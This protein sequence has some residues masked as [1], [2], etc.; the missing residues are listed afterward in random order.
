MHRLGNAFLLALIVL[1][2]TKCGFA[3]QTIVGFLGGARAAYGRGAEL[4]R[5]GEYREA[6]SV[7]ETAL[8]SDP[9][10]PD[11]HELL[12]HACVKLGDGD[13]AIDAYTRAIQRGSRRYTVYANRGAVYSLRG[14]W[15][16]ALAD[17]TEGIRIEPDNPACYYNRARIYRGLHQYAKER[18][19]LER[20]YER[21]G[22]N[23][24]AAALAQLLATCPETA[25]RDGQRAVEYA[26]EDCKQV[27]REEYP[28]LSRLAAAH[29]EAGHWDEAVRR[30]EQA[31]QL[32]EGNWR[33]F[34]RTCLELYRFHEPY[35]EF[36]LE[37]VSKQRPHTAGETLLYANVKFIAG[38][39]EEAIA[40]LRKAIELNPRLTTA[41]FLLGKWIAGKDTNEA[42]SH[43]CRCLEL[44]PKYPEAITC[45]AHVNIWLGKYR[46][47][48]A[49]AKAALQL[50]PK[51]TFARQLHAW[52]SASLGEVDQALH[53]LKELS[54]G[55]SDTTGLLS[56]RG[57][58]YL[59]Q[60][61]WN[62]AI[63]E[64]TEA[65]QH[66]PSDVLAYADRAVALSALGKA[67]EAKRDLE[68]CARLAPSLRV[69]TAA[70]MKKAENKK[71]LRP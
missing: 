20:A 39:L 67:E 66:Y 71:P 30:S 34:K 22:K 29:A 56:L 12:G 51:D 7:L 42:V 19:D 3:Q 16:T 15:E 14:D 54:Q 6:R 44:D 10:D 24:T 5:H 40:D 61:R 2:L 4:M 64:L 59:M 17:F 25:I 53:E 32:A 35:R 37:E 70:R 57:H 55:Q 58:C 33:R 49:D 8:R 47:A 45:R 1:S 38:T 36:T 60:G 27:G 50:D 9:S 21:G 52:A 69:P 41:H 31:L 43:L 23:P 28:S 62:D 63:A 26:R 11:L 48:L 68:E 65:V 46:E 13:R 18:A